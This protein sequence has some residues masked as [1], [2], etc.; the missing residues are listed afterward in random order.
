MIIESELELPEL[1][2]GEG[3]SDLRIDLGPVPKTNELASLDEEFAFNTYAGA[4]HIKGGCQIIVDPRPG[5]DPEGLRVILL[6]RIMAFLL[7]QRGWLPLHASVVTVGPQAILFLG[8]SGAGKSTTAAAFHT[9]KRHRV[10][11]DD[12]GAMR[13]GRGPVGGSTRLGASEA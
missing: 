10:I 12:I 3:K 5:I 1:P 6:G 8:P 2:R 4:F 13:A 9:R 11:S 7:R